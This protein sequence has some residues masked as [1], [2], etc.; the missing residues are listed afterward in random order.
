MKI[1]KPRLFISYSSKDMQVA[2]QFP[3]APALPEPLFNIQ[4]VPFEDIA[5]NSS[6]LIERL[7]STT[8]FT[9]KYD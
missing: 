2:E 4:G 1:N 3:K 8:L 9:V 5:K 6:E 7:N